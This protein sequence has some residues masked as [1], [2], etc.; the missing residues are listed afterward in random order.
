MLYWIELSS[1][2][3]CLFAWLVAWLVVVYPFPCVP[4]V[5]AS[6]RSLEICSPFVARQQQR[7][8]EKGWKRL[9]TYYAKFAL[10]LDPL[11][12]LN[13]RSRSWLVRLGRGFLP[14]GTA[15]SAPS[16]FSPACVVQVEDVLEQ[17][18]GKIDCCRLRDLELT[19][20]SFL[21]IN[22]VWTY[23]YHHLVMICLIVALTAESWKCVC[24]RTWF[25][26]I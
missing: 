26:L 22:A 19:F 7:T 2:V 6:L 12:P 5:P 8:N 10:V 18:Q 24:T 9:K 21:S 20:L 4:D 16:R 3:V 11:V 13:R 17:M 1:A 23:L 14:S 25:K 15:D